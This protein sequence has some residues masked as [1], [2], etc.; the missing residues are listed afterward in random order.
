MKE[1]RLQQ[2]LDQGMA[3]Y[4]ENDFESALEYFYLALKIIEKEDKVELEEVL[5]INIA[6]I[7]EEQDEKEKAFQ[8]YDII[9]LRHDS[10]AGDYGKAVLY[11]D[12]GKYD[13]A[14]EY[15]DKSLEKN[16]KNRDSLFF[17]ANLLDVMG[18]T[19]ESIR[20]YQKLL[21][22]HPYDFMTYNNLG[23]I[24]EQRGELEKAEKSFR[25][26]IEIEAYYFRSHF[27][28]AITLERMEEDEE[29]LREYL[30]AEELN[31]EYENI[32]LNLSAYF[33]RRKEFPLA[34]DSLKKGLKNHPEAANLHYNL[35]ASYSELGIWEKGVEALVKSLDCE[36]KILPFLIN[37]QQMRPL[38]ERAFK[39]SSGDILFLPLSQ[40]EDGPEMVSEFLLEKDYENLKNDFNFE[41]DFKDFLNFLR[42][43][44]QKKDAKEA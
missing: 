10:G 27:N 7:Y 20:A 1:E 5:L 19:E 13:L 26:S 24:Y 12:E 31:P 35:A 42:E 18:E 23:S 2:V 6:Q 16:P 22:I 14:L 36:P 25:K 11:E 8:V 40:L 21:E 30:L 17:R 15:Y 34:I 33:I 4:Q 43:S 9:S 38:L 3:Y 41:E 37:D 32:Y 28:L 29:A 44:F 39:E